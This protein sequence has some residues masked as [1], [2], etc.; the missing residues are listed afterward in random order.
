MPLCNDGGYFKLPA[1]QEILRNY[2]A[3]HAQFCIDITQ[4]SWKS[5]LLLLNVFNFPPLPAFQYHKNHNFV[6]K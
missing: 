6:Y 5:I 4:P 3:I 2:C 1:S